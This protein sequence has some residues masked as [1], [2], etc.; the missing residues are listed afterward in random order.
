MNQIPTFTAEQRAQLEA[1]EN[2]QLTAEELEARVQAP[3]SEHEAESFRAHVAWFTRR[4][5]TPGERL[6]AMRHL[7]QQ[8]LANKPR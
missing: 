6:A 7:T 4:Y 5:P 8:W 2:R 3:W 1:W